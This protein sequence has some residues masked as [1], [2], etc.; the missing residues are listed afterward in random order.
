[1]VLFI[2][3]DINV[4]HFICEGSVQYTMK[5]GQVLEPIALCSVYQLVPGG[6][7]IQNYRAYIDPS[8][9]LQAAQA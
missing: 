3:I 9:L 1:M 4:D 5:N 8:P 2:A 6:E 7:L